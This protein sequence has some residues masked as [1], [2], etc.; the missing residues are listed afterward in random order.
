MQP[1]M[2]RRQDQFTICLPNA[3][4]RK[5]TKLAEQDGRSRS[6]YAGRVLA[7]HLAEQES[8]AA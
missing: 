6:D 4:F 8:K 3:K 1:R 5:L 7:K 2:K